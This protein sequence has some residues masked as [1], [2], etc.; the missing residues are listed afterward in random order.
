[1]IFSVRKADYQK[2]RL[3]VC[4]SST[5]FPSSASTTMKKIEILIGGGSK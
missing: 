3:S 5:N 4:I 2:V 1:M